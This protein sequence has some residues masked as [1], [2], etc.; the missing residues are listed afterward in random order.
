[1]RLNQ[2]H[3]LPGFRE[4]HLHTSLNLLFYIE[5]KMF[6]SINFFAIIALD[7]N[8]TFRLGLNLILNRT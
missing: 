4:L 2:V 5:A 7:S 1:M 8:E 3:S 6:W